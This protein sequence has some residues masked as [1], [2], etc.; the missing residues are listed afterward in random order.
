MRRKWSQA[1]A[2][3][4]S[5]TLVIYTNTRTHTH[6]HTPVHTHVH[7]PTAHPHT[8]THKHT[9]AHAHT[10]QRRTNSGRRQDSADAGKERGVGGD[11]APEVE[12]HLED[13]R[14]VEVAERGD[15]VCGRRNR[16]VDNRRGRP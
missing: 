10:Q 12:Q 8:C 2:H 16:A 7:T 14:V 6:T 11:V 3:H 15:R 13:G 9:Y 5:D 4:A 1:E